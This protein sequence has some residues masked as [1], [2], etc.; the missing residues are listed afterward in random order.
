MNVVIDDHSDFV[1][2]SVRE[3][4]SMNIELQFPKFNIS[5]VVTILWVLVTSF[6]EILLF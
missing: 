4:D 5:R 2:N 6:L 3:Y 1:F